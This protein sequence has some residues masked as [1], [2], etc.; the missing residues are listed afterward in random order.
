MYYHRVVS[1][2]CESSNLT[3][4]ATMVGLKGPI[5][6]R[7][8]SLFGPP[9]HHVRC[10]VLPLHWHPTSKVCTFRGPRLTASIR[11]GGKKNKDN[12]RIAIEN[13]IRVR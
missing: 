9:L 10:S 7:Q 1:A 2:S 6:L 12:E 11:G 4:R 13:G 3:D 8:Y 5:D